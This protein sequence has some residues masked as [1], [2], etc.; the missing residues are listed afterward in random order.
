[1]HP[2]VVDEHAPNL[3]ILLEIEYHPYVLTH[4]DAVMK[5]HEQHN[6]VVQSYGPLTPL[7]RHP[8][9]GPIK[10]IL[11]RIAERMSKETGK[12]VDE[13]A[14]L[15]LWTMQK[16]AVALTSSSKDE[17]IKAFAETENLPDLSKDEI[18]EIES[19]GRKVY[20]RHYVSGCILDRTSGRIGG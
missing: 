17:R 19:A 3:A 6:I 14:V 20:F 11:T 4:L 8:T 9:G 5:L 18:D 2:E 16:G 15:L 7:V 1:M 10:P 12:H 13:A